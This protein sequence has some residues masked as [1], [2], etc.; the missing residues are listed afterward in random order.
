MAIK[1]K[2]AAAAATAEEQNRTELS[3]RP[4]NVEGR[5][6]K[7]EKK[8]KKTARKP[9]IDAISSAQPSSAQLPILFFAASNL[10]TTSTHWL[11]TACTAAADLLEREQVSLR[12]VSFLKRE[13]KS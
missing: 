8:D 11:L 6:E 1:V 9:E 13:G 4:L 5:K 12:K 7:E 2:T 3:T 10:I